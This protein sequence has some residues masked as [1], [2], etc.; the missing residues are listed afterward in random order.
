[1]G[2]GDGV[3]AFAAGVGFVVGTPQVWPYAAVPV[4]W[5]LLLS[6]G[7]CVGGAFGAWEAAFHVVGK[8][9]GTWGQV[10]GWLL[11]VLLAILFI[12]LAQL[13]ALA[14]AQPLS[15]FALDGIVHAQEK[16]LTGRTSPKASL[17]VSAWNALCVAALSF[18][19]CVPLLVLL[20][21]IGLLFPPATVVT[22]PLK[23]VVCGWMLAWD[24]F[25]YPLTMR[26]LGMLARLHWMSR[27]FLAVTTFGVIWA[28]LVVV[29]GIVLLLLPMGVAGATQLVVAADRAEE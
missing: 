11:T 22:I 8:E 14:L 7:G 10:G 29:P 2:V 15:G 9:A 25:D 18:L 26:G 6:C 20:F 27:H 24:F 21:V 5:L 4:S 28:L 19:V 3:S 17:L 1:L 23:F 13:A 16:A 12:L